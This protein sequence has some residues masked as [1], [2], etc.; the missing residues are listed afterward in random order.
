MRLGVVGTNFGR[1]VHVPAFRANPRCRVVALAGTDAARTSELARDAAISKGY[2]NWRALIE[3]PEVD[4]VAIAVPPAQQPEIA[5]YSLTLG[6][7]VFAEKPLAASLDDARA[8]ADMAGRSGLTAMV[9][10][11]FTMIPAWQRA[12]ELVESGALGSLSHVTVRW[13]MESRAIRHRKWSWKTSTEQ[14]G[15]V[16][17]N[18]VSHC[19][20]Y[21]EWLAGPISGLSARVFR[22]PGVDAKV[23][24]M[25]AIAFAFAS[26]ASGSLSVSCASFLGSG[27]RIELCGTD[28]ALVIMNKSPNCMG[29]FKLLLSGK[30]Y[31]DCVPVPLDDPF[32]AQ[33]L[34]VD[35][36]TG[37]VSRLV[38]RFIDSIEAGAPGYPSFQ[39]GLRVQKLIDAALQSHSDGGWKKV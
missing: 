21:L 12:K 5:I 31:D 6:K 18:F 17:G 22:L 23:D 24:S 39:D 33:D 34:L 15:G 38:T 19:F 10:F 28:G 8:M 7:P 11:E 37:P 27:H 9:D 35:D 30:T 32:E 16:I 26:G 29:G 14:G 36:R 4:A 2:G 20:H 1:F 25:A 3:D 13:E